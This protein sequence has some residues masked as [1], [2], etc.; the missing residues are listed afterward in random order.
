MYNDMSA[1]MPT[2][3]FMHMFTH[4]SVRMPTHMAVHIPAQLFVLMLVHMSM[5]H[6]C[7]GSALPAEYRC[8]SPSIESSF[9]RAHAI[10]ESRET[11][12]THLASPQPERVYRHV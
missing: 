3:M 8:V 6:L 10:S 7:E 2:H 11:R 4:I 9:R 1:Y 5:A 12:G